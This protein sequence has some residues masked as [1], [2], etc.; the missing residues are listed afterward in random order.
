MIFA[1]EIVGLAGSMSV[2]A[3]GIHLDVSLLTVNQRK[4]SEVQK[5]GDNTHTDVYIYIYMYMYIYI[6]I[7]ITDP[8]LIIFGS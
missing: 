2:F 6:Y 8:L 3:Q 1:F 7:Y 4:K 5:T